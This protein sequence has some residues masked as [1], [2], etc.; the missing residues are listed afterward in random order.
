Q[1][2][3]STSQPHH[4]AAK[5]AAAPHPN[6]PAHHDAGAGGGGGGATGGIQFAPISDWNKFLPKKLPDQDERET[7]RLIGLVKKKV[8]RDRKIVGKQLAGL[9]AA[10]LK[11]AG[12]LRAMKG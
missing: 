2:H 10:Q 7:N 8:E 9:H 12:Q 1:A 4:P 3:P 5:H 6:A 11:V